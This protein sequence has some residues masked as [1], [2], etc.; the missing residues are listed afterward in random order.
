MEPF[1]LRLIRDKENTAKDDHVKISYLSYGIY[2]I[3]TKYSQKYSQG[4]S[5]VQNLSDRDI[6]DYVHSLMILLIHDTDPFKFV[7]IDAPNT[8]SILLAIKD[9][10]SER[11][12][13]AIDNLLRVTLSSWSRSLP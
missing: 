8:P 12:Y 6:F 2:Q 9:L 10:D 5:S 1:V 4:K 11:L 13:H 3:N 7:Q